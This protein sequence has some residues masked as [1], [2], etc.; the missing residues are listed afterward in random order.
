LC[1]GVWVLG[2]G[3]T[4]INNN[5]IDS[6]GWLNGKYA[7]NMQGSHL[8]H[9]RLTRLLYQAF[10][11]ENNTIG[12]HSDP[13]D[14]YIYNTLQYV[15]GKYLSGFSTT[16]NHIYNNNSGSAKITVQSGIVYSTT[17]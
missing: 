10:I 16:A 11:I 17:P 14:I 12:K 3:T 8:T 1:E 5:K 4:T 13:A 7:G 9:G 15:Q 6:S 2:C